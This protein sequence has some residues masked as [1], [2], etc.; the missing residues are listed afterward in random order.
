MNTWFGIGNLTRDPELKIVGSGT[1]LTKFSVAINSK[2]KG[3]DQKWID[4]VDFVE[5]SLFGKSAAKF[6]E[7]MA[8][9]RKVAIKGELRTDTWDDKETGAKRSRTFVMVNDWTMCDSKQGGQKPANS[10]SAPDED[11]PF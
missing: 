11:T 7:Y 10:E 2:M 1:E 6:C 8:K 5:C 9:G 4:R 3:P